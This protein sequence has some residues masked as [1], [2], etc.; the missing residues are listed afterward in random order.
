MEIKELIIGD[1]KF[2]SLEDKG[3][4][5]VNLTCNGILVDNEWNWNRI[6]PKSGHVAELLFQGS[7]PR[8]TGIPHSRTNTYFV[9]DPC[10]KRV[11]SRSDFCI[12]L[13]IIE[14]EEDHFKLVPI[15]EIGE[16]K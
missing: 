10:I 2:H 8:I 3:T 9:V 11:S 16:N 14:Y 12:S 6:L 15:F 13:Q 1:Q 5:F 7:I 4:Y